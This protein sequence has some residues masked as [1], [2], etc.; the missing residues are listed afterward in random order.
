MIPGIHQNALTPPKF[1]A[2]QNTALSGQGRLG[3]SI[4]P[5]LTPSARRNTSHTSYLI[6]HLHTPSPSF[7]ANAPGPLA[8][9]QELCFI[10]HHIPSPTA[11][12]LDRVFSTGGNYPMRPH[13]LPT[14]KE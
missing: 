3:V 9:E 1:L 14:P 4:S 6:Y 12:N 7:N 10:A 5:S 13:T 11:Q 2:L 8:P